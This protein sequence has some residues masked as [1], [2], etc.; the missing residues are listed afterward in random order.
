L[1]LGIQWPP[2]LPEAEIAASKNRQIVQFRE[3]RWIQWL[4]KL[5]R[6]RRKRS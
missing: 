2:V 3:K 1:K 6:R 5:E 4:E